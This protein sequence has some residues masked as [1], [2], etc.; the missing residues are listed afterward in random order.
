MFNEDLKLEFEYTTINK[1]TKTA[2]NHINSFLSY[3]SQQIKRFTTQHVLIFSKNEIKSMEI[4]RQK[5][6]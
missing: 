4:Y 1:I 5:R 6:H 3:K 2:K